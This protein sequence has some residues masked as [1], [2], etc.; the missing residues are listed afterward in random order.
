MI[1]YSRWCIIKSLW[2]LSLVSCIWTTAMR[3]CEEVKPSR[4]PANQKDRDSSRQR[5]NEAKAQR[6]Q[7]EIEALSV[8]K[9]QS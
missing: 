3:I 9:L 2:T 4:S 7:H 1:P 8:I 6:P 5:Q